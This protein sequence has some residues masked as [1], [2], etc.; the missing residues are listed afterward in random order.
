MNDLQHLPTLATEN[1]EHGA[2]WLGTLRTW[3]PMGVSAIYPHMQQASTLAGGT[4]Q[5]ED[6]CGV[7][8]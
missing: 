5:S 6:G 3:N 8:A 7:I 2:P 1:I 4:N